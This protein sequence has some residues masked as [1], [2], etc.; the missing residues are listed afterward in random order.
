MEIALKSRN[1]S[2]RHLLLD[3]MYGTDVFI[4][5][6]SVLVLISLSHELVRFLSHIKCGLSA[7][8]IYVTG[9]G[10]RECAWRS[11]TRGRVP[12]QCQGR[13]VFTEIAAHKNTQREYLAK[14]E[15]TL[16]A[17]HSFNNNYCYFGLGN[18]NKFK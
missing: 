15:R 9:R 7:H 11:V 1:Q 2:L 4:F 13:T 10:A 3:K 16:R 12:T 8:I 17:S 5:G 6:I 14:Y 18:K